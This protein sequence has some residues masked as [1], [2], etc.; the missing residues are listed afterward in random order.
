MMSFFEFGTMYNTASEPEGTVK[1][2]F[3]SVIL[4]KFSLG[5]TL[6]KD[7]RFFTLFPSTIASKIAVY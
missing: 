5:L 3:F 7:Q 4:Y 2:V 6:L 1:F